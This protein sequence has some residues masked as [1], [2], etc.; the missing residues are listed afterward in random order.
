M[1]KNNMSPSVFAD[2]FAD[3][4]NAGVLMTRS[5]EHFERL[6]QFRQLF[7]RDVIASG[8]EEAVGLL[9]RSDV[10][11]LTD[12]LRGRGRPYPLD[13][14]VQEYWPALR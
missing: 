3:Y 5:Y 12:P 6:I 8:R 4:L 7:P 10:V 13:S 11:F 9:A 2:G 14:A 1:E